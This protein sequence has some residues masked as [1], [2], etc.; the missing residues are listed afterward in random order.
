MS[1]FDQLHQEAFGTPI[2]VGG[3]PDS[4]NGFYSDKL[5]YKDWFIFNN[6]Q[7]A[8]INFWE[9]FAPVVV[10]TGITAINLPITAAVCGFTLCF[11]RIIYSIGYCAKGP[12]G[13]IVGAILFDLA[14][15]AVFVGA[16]VSLA[17]WKLDDKTQL[18]AVQ[19]VTN[20][21]VLPITNSKFQALFP[22]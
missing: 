9:T 2:Q 7:R 22:I 19:Y 21:K 15:V 20:M 18:N 8:Q 6:W 12:S 16:I 17:Y 4:G 14:L 5:S 11:G 13:R 1:Q 3:Y 10:L